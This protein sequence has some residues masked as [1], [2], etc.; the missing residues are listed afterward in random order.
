M[1]NLRSEGDTSQTTNLLCVVTQAASKPARAILLLIKKF[2]CRDAVFSQCGVV[3]FAQTDR[4]AS[5]WP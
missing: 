2:N 3:I 5:E 1:E 4:P